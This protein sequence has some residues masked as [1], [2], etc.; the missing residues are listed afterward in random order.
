HRDVPD[1]IV[2]ELLDAIV[3]AAAKGDVRRR[4][5]QG[6]VIKLGDL[7]PC[8]V[9]VPP[10]PG[11]GVR[12]LVRP[13]VGTDGQLPMSGIV[14]SV[15]GEHVLIVMNRQGRAGVKSPAAATV[16][17]LPDLVTGHINDVGIARVHRD[18]IAVLA[19]A[20]KEEV[21]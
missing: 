18:G 2:L 1:Y 11:T 10:E 19:L 15:P 16:A 6:H 5:I 7:R 4:W 14:D 13:T 8:D 3:L 12:Q 20:V 9:E 21:V 17:A